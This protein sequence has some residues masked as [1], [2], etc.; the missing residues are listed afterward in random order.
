[1]TEEQLLGIADDYGSD[2]PWALLLLDE[3]NKDIPDQFDGYLAELLQKADMTAV[4][5][6]IFVNTWIDG[7]P[8]TR[9]YD[10]LEEALNYDV[11]G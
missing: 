4:E 1:M 6:V 7:Y 11:D 2:R 5:K 8:H 10:R 3:I 9:T